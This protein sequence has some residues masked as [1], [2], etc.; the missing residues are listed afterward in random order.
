MQNKNRVIRNR[1]GSGCAFGIIAQEILMEEMGL[2]T[3]VLHIFF[4]VK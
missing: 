4:S 1:S 3:A 2:S